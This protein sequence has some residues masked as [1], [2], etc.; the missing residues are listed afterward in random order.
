MLLGALLT[1]QG[2]SLTPSS[3]HPRHPPAQFLNYALRRL[4]LDECA[5]AHL[6]GHYVSHTFE[7]HVAAFS[8]ATK[9]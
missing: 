1:S 4:W 3:N 7:E 6:R 8:D 2:S 9:K 5:P